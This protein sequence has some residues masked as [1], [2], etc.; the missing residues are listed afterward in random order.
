MFICISCKG[1]DSG[2]QKRTLVPLNWSYR[3]LWAASRVLSMEPGSS[4][5]APSA[6]NHWAISPVPKYAY[7]KRNSKHSSFLPH[8]IASVKISAMWS[9]SK[10][11]M[12][13][14]VY[15]DLYLSFPNA[16][17]FHKH[18]PTILIYMV[19]VWNLDWGNVEMNKGQILKKWQAHGYRK[20]DGI[21]PTQQ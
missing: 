3:W 17:H 18:M 16:L 7:C 20:A 8:G 13:E 9:W 10:V 2:T 19:R 11:C 1:S 21:T 14:S 5:K 15:A 4:G 12:C 6:L